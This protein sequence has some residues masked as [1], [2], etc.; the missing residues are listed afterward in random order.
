MVI[1]N[2]MGVEKFLLEIVNERV[3]QVK[4]SLEGTIGH[5]STAAQE[6]YNLIEHLIEVHDRLFERSSRNAFASLRPNV[7]NAGIIYTLQQANGRGDA[8]PRAWPG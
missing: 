6:A 3:I 5:T 2:R 7:S 4:L 1:D 8:A